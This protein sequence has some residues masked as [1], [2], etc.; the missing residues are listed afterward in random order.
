M[1]TQTTVTRAPVQLSDEEIQR[2]LA[3]SNS[4]QDSSGDDDE[5]V[6]ERSESQAPP[7]PQ[8]QTT[9]SRTPSKMGGRERLNSKS[10]SPSRS[11]QLVSISRIGEPN[12]LSHLSLEVHNPKQKTKLLITLM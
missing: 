11:P 12:H 8:A 1:F 5:E 6:I 7:A 4:F 9:R 3:R 2:I 10:L